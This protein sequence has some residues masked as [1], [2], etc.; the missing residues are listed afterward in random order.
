[1]AKSRVTHTCGHTS[2]V[3][4]Y[5]RKECDYRAE[6]AE[7]ELCWDCYREQQ[8]GAAAE[9]TA[10]LNL[11]P[12]VGTEKQIAWANSIR[13]KVLADIPKVLRASAEYAEAARAQ[14][15]ERAAEINAV[16]ALVEKAGDRLRT[17][18]SAK[19]WIDNRDSSADS[20]VRQIA[21]R[22]QESLR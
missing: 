20:L 1:M 15:P 4:A 9:R 5:N 21:R 14:S 8:Q 16:E 17:E 7:S 12:L 18:T 19:W 10:E 2:T 13:L 6:R 3:T 22:L 11:I